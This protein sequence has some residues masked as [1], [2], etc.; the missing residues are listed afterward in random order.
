[1]SCHVSTAV[2]E[3]EVEKYDR[4]SAH[5]TFLVSATPMT[6]FIHDQL[7]SC[8]AKGAKSVKARISCLFMARS[9]AR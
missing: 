5:L 3:H 4:D 8:G 1:M 7:A 2:S 9:P 6:V